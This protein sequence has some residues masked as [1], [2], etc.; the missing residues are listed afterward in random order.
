MLFSDDCKAERHPD[1]AKVPNDCLSLTPEWRESET[2]IIIRTNHHSSRS[3]IPELKGTQGYSSWCN[4]LRNSIPQ[5]IQA[6]LY[7]QQWNW[8]AFQRI[9]PSACSLP[10]QGSWNAE[11][12]IESF[13][14]H[15]MHFDTEWERTDTY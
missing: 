1:L 6:S 12:W 10:F 15:P 14:P 5:R 8:A 3:G 11:R 7:K 9:Y 4:M 13:D 2:A